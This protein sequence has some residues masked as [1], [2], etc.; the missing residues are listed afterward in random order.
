[1]L[2]AAATQGYWLVRCRWWE[3][4]VLLLVAFTLLRPG[5]W[6]DRWQEPWQHYVGSALMEQLEQTGR[7]LTLRLDVEGPDFDRPEELNSLTILLELKADQSL[8]QALDEN[9]ILIQIDAES[10]VLEE[11]MPGS[12]Y[13]QPFQRFDFYMDDPVRL[14]TVLESQVNRPAKEWFYLPALALL[15]LVWFAQRRRLRIASAQG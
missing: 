14:I 12:T 5:Y 13:F 15:A 11:P 3:T 10:V 7:D 1:M 9:V 4:I 6:L 8:Q 2:F